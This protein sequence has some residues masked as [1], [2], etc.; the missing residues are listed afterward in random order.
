MIT[1]RTQPRDA[2]RSRLLER[3]LACAPALLAGI[4][5][6][7]VP[8]LSRAATHEVASFGAAPNDDRDDAAA[9]QA[10]ID[11]SSAGDTVRLPEGTFLV[12]RTLHA[13]TGVKILGAGRDR[14]VLKFNARTQ[15]DIFDLSG[16][17]Q[18]ELSG[19]T[20]EGGGDSNAHHGIFA[21]TGGGHLIHDLAIQN[22]GS[23]NGPLAIHF[24]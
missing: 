15:T 12:N 7:M 3:L 20:L 6:V 11:A 19:F 8:A 10:A 16:A 4:A 1:A 9:I 21:R 5:L 24:I 18:V 22:L 13:R 23:A 17:R 14:T 2:A